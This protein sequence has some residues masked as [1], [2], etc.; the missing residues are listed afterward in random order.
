LDRDSLV[1]VVAQ[2]CPFPGDR[3]CEIGI[4]EGIPS[5]LI[6]DGSELDPTW[7]EGKATVGL[8]AGAS[9]PEALVLD[10][11]DALRRIDSNIEVCQMDGIKE[12]IEF[13]LPAE[14]RS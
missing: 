6:A 9:A 11:V 7:L 13:R 10:V 12:H 8:T 14:L 5:Y 1:T 3:L 2:R 4:E